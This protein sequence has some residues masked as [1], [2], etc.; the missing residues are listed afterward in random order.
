M[1][2]SPNPLIDNDRPSCAGPQ[3]ALAKLAA[4]WLQQHFSALPQT[5][6]RQPNMTYIAAGLIL[7]IA[8]ATTGCRNLGETKKFH[9]AGLATK[10]LSLDG[11]TRRYAIYVPEKPGATNLPLVFELHG[12]GVSI[13][14][15]TGESGYKTPYKLWMDL[16]DSEKFIVVYPEGLNGAYGK[17]T[18]NDCRAN[19]SVNSGADD[20]QFISALIDLI[21]AAHDIDPDSI[22]ASGTSN[23]GLMTLRL[24]VE[25]PD[26]IAAVAAVAAAMPDH[27]ECRPP[28][29]PISVLFMNGTNDNHLPYHGGILSNPPNPDHGSVYSTA[30][31]V[32]IW[33]AINHTD[34]IPV[35][36]NFPDL[37]TKDGSTV[38]SYNYAN[39][40]KGKEVALYEVTGG[41]HS[42]PSIRE[43]YS[44][45]FERYFNRQNHDIEMTTEVWKFF[46]GKNREHQQCF[47]KSRPP[48][49]PHAATESAKIVHIPPPGW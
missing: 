35:S 15:M 1:P 6:M 14:D 44:A 17:P 3:A 27:S 33:K 26:K 18:W 4:G 38:T 29:Q 10:S 46:R 45:L 24:A 21:S 20:V 37:D 39:G 47:S 43:Q 28:A 13:E 7:A 23:G 25:L 22:Y 49:L 42:A 36:C 16:A 2:E 5:N 41:G 30:T 40:V 31:S 12:G 34:Q 48:G 11:V 32:A 8:T 19:A 9:R